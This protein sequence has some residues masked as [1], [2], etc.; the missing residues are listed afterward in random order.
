MT[1][2]TATALKPLPTEV[3]TKAS[4]RTTKCR[5]QG[6]TSGPRGKLM[7][8]NGST[9]SNTGRGPGQTPKAILTSDN[10]NKAKPQVL[11]YF[12]KPTVPGMKVLSPSSSKTGKELKNSLLGIFTKGAMLMVFSTGRESTFGVT[13]AFTRETSKTVSSTDTESSKRH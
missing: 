7:K 9:I 2:G 4:I 10:G 5:E 3:T 1:R 13:A 12:P 11:G 8:A 6:S